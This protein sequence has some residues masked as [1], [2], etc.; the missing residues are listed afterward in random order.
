MNLPIP[1]VNRNGHKVWEINGARVE[2]M[3][4][5]LTPSYLAGDCYALVSGIGH[6]RLTSL[7]DAMT[8]AILARQSF[9]NLQ[10]P[11]VTVEQQNHA[12]AASVG[13]MQTSTGQMVTADEWDDI[14][15]SM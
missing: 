2:E 15:N 14:E 5:G 9:L 12:F 6:S 11:T 1:T 13:M 7:S 8:K 3:S 10:K 4:D